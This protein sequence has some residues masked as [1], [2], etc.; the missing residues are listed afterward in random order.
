MQNGQRL[1]KSLLVGTGYVLTSIF[2]ISFAGLCM[3][4]V[5]VMK[6]LKSVVALHDIEWIPC[7][8]CARKFVPLDGKPVFTSQL[9]AVIEIC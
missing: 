4:T 5:I 3:M 9:E 2:K 1:E 7:S 8:K 6:F